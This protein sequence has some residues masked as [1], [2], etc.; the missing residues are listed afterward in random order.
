MKL[1]KKQK[2]TLAILGH[3]AVCACATY[4]A[5]KLL[6]AESAGDIIKEAA[7]AASEL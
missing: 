6:D 2:W 7:A 5:V 4:V 1:S 3:V